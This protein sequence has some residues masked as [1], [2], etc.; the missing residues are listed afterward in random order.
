MPLGQ[1][2]DIFYQTP[3]QYSSALEITTPEIQKAFKKGT[4]G[5]FYL[6]LNLVL[7]FSCPSQLRYNS[8]DE[9]VGIPEQLGYLYTK[10]SF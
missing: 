5:K 2:Q 6:N 9:R 10:H 8:K 1:F 4:F 3:I 7:Y